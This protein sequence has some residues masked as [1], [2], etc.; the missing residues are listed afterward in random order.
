MLEETRSALKLTRM[1]KYWRSKRRLGQDMFGCFLF[2]FLYRLYLYHWIHHH[3]QFHQ[4]GMIY[5][6][7]STSFH[8]SNM[9]IQG[10]L[11]GNDCNFAH[12]KQE[13]RTTDLTATKLCYG[14]TRFGHCSKGDT[15]TFAHGHNELRSSQELVDRQMVAS[16]GSTSISLDALKLS[17][18]SQL[19]F[20]ASFLS[21]RPPPG[22]E[23]PSFHS[24]Y[25]HQESSS[26]ASSQSVC[27]D[28]ESDKQTRQPTFWL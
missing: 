26:S 2:L 14:F 7:V 23:A 4:F 3:E 27:S 13:L 12:S 25:Q 1:C 17:Q 28:S 15:C 9:H 20:D 10:C 19:D 18:V 24:F 21:F 11:M 16:V 22:L 6:L 5:N 8:A